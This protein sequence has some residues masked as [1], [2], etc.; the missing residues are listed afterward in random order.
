[1][2]LRRARL[3]A[4]LE[5]RE[6]TALLLQGARGSTLN[7][8]H[9][10]LADILVCRDNVEVQILSKDDDA[11][12]LCVVAGLRRNHFAVLRGP[13]R[14]L[15]GDRLG[16]FSEEVEHVLQRGRVILLELAKILRVIEGKAYVDLNSVS[17]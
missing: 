4:A 15:G 2:R 1:M 6:D 13:G 14:G 9:S 12:P 5:A 3:V 8:Q 16:Y 7:F 11:G 17:F 10:C